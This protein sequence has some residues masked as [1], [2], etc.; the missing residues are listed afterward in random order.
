MDFLFS[1]L[2]EE[3]EMK[4]NLLIG[5]GATL[6]LALGGCGTANSSAAKSDDS[7]TIGVLQL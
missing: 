1:K 2:K 6:L 4:K 5:L 3:K 7:K